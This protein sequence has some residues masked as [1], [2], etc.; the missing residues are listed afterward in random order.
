MN[1]ELS[2][3]ELQ[4][5]QSRYERYELE[6]KER[7]ELEDKERRRAEA[8]PKILA[9]SAGS[10]FV[11]LGLVLLTVIFV[12]QWIVGLILSLGILAGIFIFA[13]ESMD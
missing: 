10:L 9:I 12:W 6:R 4:R 1:E 5:W 13:M 7:M 2:T 11:L 8:I 3:E